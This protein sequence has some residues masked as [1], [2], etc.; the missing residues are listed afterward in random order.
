VDEGDCRHSYRAAC[1]Y[2][3]LEHY[4]FQKK[5]DIP[6]PAKQSFRVLTVINGTI[7]LAYAAG[8]AEVSSGT[9]VVLPAVL[10]DVRA[11][12]S[13]GSEFLLSSVPDLQNEIIAP[14]RQRGTPDA[15]IAALGGFPE[16]NDL[17]DFL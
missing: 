14:L 1:R 9:T 8:K 13:A 12:G 16:R 17:A 3:A 2:F 5:T 15:A 4:A 11:S 7:K 6:L 10:R